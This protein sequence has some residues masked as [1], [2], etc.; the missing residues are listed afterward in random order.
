MYDARGFF[1]PVSM[2]STLI[3]LVIMFSFMVD[4]RKPVC[5]RFL[6]VLL[7][8]DLADTDMGLC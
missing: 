2:G 5:M 6:L 4:V 7:P 8:G 3:L 1:V